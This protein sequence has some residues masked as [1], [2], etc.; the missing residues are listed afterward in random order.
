M[1]F[2][3]LPI[4]FAP[5]RIGV[6]GV[7]ALRG[8]LNARI[9]RACEQEYGRRTAELL[10]RARQDQVFAQAC[11]ARMTGD[12]RSTF[13]AVLGVPARRGHGLGPGLRKCSVR[14]ALRAVP[15]VDS[16]PTP[17]LAL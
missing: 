12:Q 7:C 6:C 17:A 11:L 1:S 16:V 13:I 9:C 2:T 15:R 14:P 3:Q 8:V 10:A 5:T 4:Q